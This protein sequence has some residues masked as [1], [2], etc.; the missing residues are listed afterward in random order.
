MKQFQSSDID[1]TVLHDKT[2]AII[3]YGSQGRAQALNLRDS[4]IAVLIGVRNENSASAK[5]A[6]AD[7]FEVSP[8]NAAAAAADLIM[9]LTPDETHAE[10]HAELARGTNL[11]GKTIGFAHGYA[12]TFGLLDK[13][14]ENT[15]PANVSDPA[16]PFNPAKPAASSGLPDI[17]LVSPKGIGPAVRSQYLKG[18]GV[19]ALVAVARDSTGQA[20]Q[21]ALAYASAIGSDRVGIFQTSFKEETIADLFSEQAVIVGGMTALIKAGF[22]TMVAKGI[23]PEIAYF[24]CVVEAKLILDMIVES[25]FSTMFEQIS[26]TAEYGAYTAGHKVIDADTTNRMAEIFDESASG[27]FAKAWNAECAH[28][29]PT[30]QKQRKIW[31]ESL[32]DQTATHMRNIGK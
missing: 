30:L 1:K 11:A 2:V 19:A 6:V 10:L 16:N 27:D 12:Q 26:N 28:N 17:I 18:S 3:G 25:G 20:L 21:L 23:A 8:L 5:Q 24:E 22:D 31:K 14:S 15:E 13:S 4:N 9:L 7:G 29:M 32:I